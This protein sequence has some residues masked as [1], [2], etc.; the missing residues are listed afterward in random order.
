VDNLPFFPETQKYLVPLM[1]AYPDSF[2]VV[3]TTPQPQNYVLKIK[4]N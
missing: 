2:E 1:Q 4:K 3:Y